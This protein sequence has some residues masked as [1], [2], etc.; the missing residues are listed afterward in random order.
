MNQIHE[1]FMSLALREAESAFMEDEVPVGAVLVQGD[2]VL[3]AAHNR[4][5]S[6]SDPTTH[7]ELLALQQGAPKTGSWRLTDAVLYVTKEPCVMCAGAMLNARLGTLV[8]GCKDERYG[9][10]FSIYNILNDRRLN[11]QVEI[12]SGI[13]EDECSEILKRFFVTLRKNPDNYR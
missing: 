12:V 1:H 6:T 3:A 7:A 10:V 2:T 13:L 9:A 4:R 5:E 8:F 11:H